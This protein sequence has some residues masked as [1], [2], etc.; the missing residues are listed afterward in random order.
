M[1][2]STYSLSLHFLRVAVFAFL[3]VAV[4]ALSAPVAYGAP[5]ANGDE[6]T[7]NEDTSI[8]IDVLA[9]DLPN[10]ESLTI[11][12][13]TLGL[14]WYGTVVIE[15]N[16]LR[17]TPFQNLNDVINLGPDFFSYT[18]TDGVN[19]SYPGYVIVNVSPVNDAPSF[20]VAS[21]APAVDEDSGAQTVAG[22]ATGIR[23]GP[24]TATDESGQSLNFTVTGNTNLDLFSSGPAVD[25]TTGNLTYTPAANAY[26]T[27]VI[28]IVLHDNGGTENE[29]E[30]TSEQQTF[31]I[32]VNAVNDPP[33]FDAVSS[34]DP[35]LRRHQ[36]KEGR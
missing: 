8:L 34:P 2:L 17:Y 25:A 13:D 11:E 3:L 29:G 12:A 4:G 27:A 10:P 18:V 14:P 31:S 6:A 36:K 33:S 16:A 15:G 26:G 35:D 7:T 22:F 21:S 30:D 1:I 9:N 5:T 28:T 20:S 19:S 23:P 32:T 24:E